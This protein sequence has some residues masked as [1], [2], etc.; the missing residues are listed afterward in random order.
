VRKKLEKSQRDR[1]EE[2]KN[3]HEAMED[4]TQAH[5]AAGAETEQLRQQVWNLSEL[6]FP[7]RY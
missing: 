4:M 3:H 2:A 1:N 6:E 7:T 5:N